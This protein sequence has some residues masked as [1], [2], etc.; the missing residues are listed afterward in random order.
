MI[1]AYVVGGFFLLHFSHTSDTETLFFKC[2]RKISISFQVDIFFFDLS[3][4]DLLRI[5]PYFTILKT[6]I[7]SEAEQYHL[8]PTFRY[9]RRKEGFKDVYGY[10]LN[11]HF[12]PVEIYMKYSQIH[13]SNYG[14]SLQLYSSNSKSIIYY[15]TFQSN[16]LSHEVKTALMFSTGVSFPHSH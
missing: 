3:C 4:S 15:K 2:S 9:H 16:T 5:P 12:I 13:L 7:P 8:I 11:V 10:R 1:W 14:K 6:P